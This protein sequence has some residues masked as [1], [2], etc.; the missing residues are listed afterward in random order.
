MKMDLEALA[1]IIEGCVPTAK[2]VCLP[3]INQIVVSFSDRDN[4]EVSALTPY[5][6]SR[7]MSGKISY[8]DIDLMVE[9]VKSIASPH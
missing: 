8:D 2:T 1:K 9:E 6:Q 3:E 7:L 5:L 4:I